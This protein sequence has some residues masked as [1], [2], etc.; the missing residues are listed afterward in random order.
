MRLFDIKSE[1]SPLGGCVRLLD[2]REGCVELR[3][4]WCRVLTR[5]GEHFEVCVKHLELSK[6]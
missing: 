2:M 1:L 3:E 5:L 4:R 6:V